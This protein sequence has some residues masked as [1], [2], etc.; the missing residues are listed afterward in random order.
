[1]VGRARGT[2][3]CSLCDLTHGRIRERPA[4][5]QLRDRLGLPVDLVH[6]NE[7]DERLRSLDVG[8]PC[9]AAVTGDEVR[10]LLGPAD[11]EACRGD[12]DALERRL[13]AALDA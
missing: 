3:H 10:P 2:A 9:I 11:L 13:R 8:L 12:L 1:M 5:R 4:W 7:R 6:R